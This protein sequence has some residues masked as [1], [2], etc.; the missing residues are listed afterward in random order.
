M[1]LYAGY[2]ASRISSKLKGSTKQFGWLQDFHLLAELRQQSDLRTVPRKGSKDRQW[3]RFKGTD[4]DSLNVSAPIVS[5]AM[6]SGV[7][8]GHTRPVR[9]CKMGANPRAYWV[10]NEVKGG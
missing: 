10:K 8:V 1:T 3:N 9:G 6:R 4:W 7:D 2:A 5:F